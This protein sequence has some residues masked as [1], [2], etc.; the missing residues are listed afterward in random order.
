MHI[1]YT[2][3]RL[4]EADTLLKEAEKRLE[5]HQN[6]LDLHSYVMAQGWLTM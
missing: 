3:E 2:S 1:P 6:S 5:E 4:G